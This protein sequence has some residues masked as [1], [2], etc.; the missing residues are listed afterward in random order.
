MSYQFDNKYPS[1]FEV[2]RDILEIGRRMYAK[3]LWL[4][5]MEIS[6]PKSVKIPSGVRLPAY[7]GIYDR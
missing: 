6:A 5:M 3:I 2:K 7:Q 1:D 4:P